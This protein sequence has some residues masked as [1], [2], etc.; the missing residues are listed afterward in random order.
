MTKHVWIMPRAL[1]CV[2]VHI[3]VA[4]DSST[5]PAT[6]SLNTTAMSFADFTIGIASALSA[7]TT[8]PHAQIYLPPATATPA[9]HRNDE[10]VFSVSSVRR[11]SLTAESIASGLIGLVTEAGCQGIAHVLGIENFAAL[12]VD[13]EQRFGACR[14][15]REPGCSAAPCH[16]ISVRATKDR[17]EAFCTAQV[18][19]LAAL[20]RRSTGKRRCYAPRWMKGKSQQKR[21]A[22]ALTAVHDK[23]KRLKFGRLGRCARVSAQCRK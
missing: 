4:G 12:R 7:V 10:T 9:F 23:R 16:H 20:G 6:Q 18:R 19:C 1:F 13:H 8:V 11:P 3:C 2:G 17:V 22:D 5:E 21:C 14:A 15:H